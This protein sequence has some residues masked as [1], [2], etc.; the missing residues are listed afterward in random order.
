VRSRGDGH[1]K[2]RRSSAP[3]KGVGRSPNRPA[4]GARLGH[5]AGATRVVGVE[6][7]IEAPRDRRRIPSLSRGAPASHE[8]WGATSWGRLA[9]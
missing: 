2:S 3:I 8:N 9:A 6:T 1:H 4:V 5:H 7:L